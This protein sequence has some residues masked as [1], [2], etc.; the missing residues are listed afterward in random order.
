MAS[1]PD[2]ASPLAVTG[3]Q[4]CCGRQTM[5]DIA[6]T[7][8]LMDSHLAQMGMG[9]TATSDDSPHPYEA[10]INALV[11]GKEFE[12]NEPVY[13]GRLED[14]PLIM[15][16]TKKEL[17]IM[18]AELKQVP[19][20]AIDLE[21]HDLHSYHGFTCLIQ[22]SSRSKDYIIDPFGLFDE[23]HVLNEI[24]CDPAILKVFHGADLDIQWLQRD[25]GVYVVNMFD[26]GQACRVLSLPGGASL[27]N[28]YELKCGFSPDMKHQ[29]SDWRQRPLP[30]AMIEYARSTTHYL[31]YAYDVL[32]QDL[33]TREM[34]LKVW[35]KSR[36]LTLQRYR[37]RQP[38]FKEIATK[39]ASRY[40]KGQLKGANFAALESLLAWRDQDAR[41]SDV[42]P[43]YCCPDHVCFVLAQKLPSADKIAQA[44][45]PLPFPPR[46][47]AQADAVVR[48]LELATLTSAGVP[49][50]PS[51]PPRKSSLGMPL[52][53]L[54]QV[55]E[56]RCVLLRD[57]FRNYLGTA[58]GG[59]I[60]GHEKDGKVQTLLEILRVAPP[61]EPPIPLKE[62][63]Y[64]V[65]PLSDLSRS[66]QEELLVEDILFCMAGVEGVYMRDHDE[67]FVLEDTS[68]DLS[69]YALAQP[70]IPL[71]NDI[72]RVQRVIKLN[73]GLDCG[74]VNQALC[75]A[76][77]QLMK[78]SLVRNAQL[79]AAF[80]E[81]NLNL[82]SLKYTV[83]SSFIT[84]N[85]LRRVADAVEGKKG[86]Q[87]LN[88]VD[89]VNERYGLPFDK[90]GTFLMER[91]AEPMF[92]MVTKWIYEGQID[93]VGDEFFIKE[94][95]MYSAKDHASEYWSKRFVL[96]TSQVPV[97]L[98]S[99]KD[100]ILHT[101]KHLNVL[102]STQLPKDVVVD[103]PE[104]PRVPLRYT[105]RHERDYVRVIEAAHDW[106]SRSLLKL[107]SSPSA[108]DL[109]GRLRT[110]RNFFFMG[111]ADYFGHFMDHA[112]SELEKDLRHAQFSR[113]EG[114]LD[115]AIRTA[116]T[117]SDPYKEDISCTLHNFSIADAAKRL[118]RQGEKSDEKTGMLTDEKAI[119]FFS[120]KY[121]VSWPWNLV[122]TR[123][124]LL[125]YQLIFRHLLYCRYVE[126]KLV[127]VWTV[128]SASKH[129]AK[130]GINSYAIRQ[131]ML[132]VCRNYIF[133]V[134]VEVLEPQFHLMM[135]RLNSCKTL[136]DVIRIHD[137]FL[138][139]CLTEILLMGKDALYQ[140]LTK[141]LATCVSFADSILSLHQQQF[142]GGSDSRAD[143]ELMG[144]LLSK[145]AY[146]NLIVKFEAIFGAQLVAF[147]KLLNQEAGRRAMD[148][149]HLANLL[150]RLDYNDFFSGNKMK[151]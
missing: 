111:Q 57:H 35:T 22:L 98:T 116:S 87:V 32:K 34:I 21:H 58:R 97:F 51:S 23:L 15:V 4:I 44:I 103:E 74:W 125:K 48:A 107:F 136:D 151:T 90:I 122:L 62:V 133:Y 131:R 59:E 126:R 114:L 80:R 92:A 64:R 7:D 130:N 65:V 146:S 43:Q 72:R 134:A 139:T 119:R 33:E 123:T 63:R 145:E 115:L 110:L 96:D 49:S 53:E 120:L 118:E 101:G 75:L 100:K 93:D 50:F 55:S 69:I 24:T 138:D 46:V 104:K 11:P 9:A 127:E 76:L 41:E 66:R 102:R 67:E 27:R 84:M 47:R 108:L 129:L 81:G 112:T 121:K 13:F 132:H 85:M 42:N 40:G 135:S 106:A 29:T 143:A 88:A 54:P 124:V 31:L 79:E 19:E 10:E 70:F 37:Q 82:S 140:Y 78:E 99:L 141:L 18:I 128:H 117:C 86:G 28:L 52:M 1:Q 150:T 39:I 105:S 71:C 73:Q 89:E 12:I 36:D 17:D 149:V 60:R 61:P 3:N 56:V 26:T 16:N 113:L 38:N 5:E 68:G 2:A 30:D 83:Q 137:G 148:H 14:T 8:D 20:I 25:F 94:N 77:S 6:V 91:A 147:L 144:K 142:S 109:K 45:H 95:S